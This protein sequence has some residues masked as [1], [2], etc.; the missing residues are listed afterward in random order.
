M[1]LF[2]NLK[3]MLYKV[4]LKMFIKNGLKLGKNVRIIGL[5]CFGSEP[6]LIKIG[7]N[8]TITAGVRFVNHDGGTSVFRRQDKYK[9]INKYGKIE[10]K[11]NCFIGTRS[12]IMPNVTI[13]PNSVIGA[14]SVVTKDIPP[15]VCA[16]GNP[17]RVICTIDEYIE[18]SEKGSIKF[19][20][21]LKS[22]REFLE[23]YFWGTE[24]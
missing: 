4:R 8:C 20:K 2:A 14:G 11:E 23:K 5:P 1:L 9:H 15:N 24:E 10:I 18:K 6:Y 21:E 19:P 12:I 7:D 17:A 22:K 13:G 16:A 3:N